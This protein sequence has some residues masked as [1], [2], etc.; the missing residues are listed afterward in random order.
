MTWNGIFGPKRKFESIKLSKTFLNCPKIWK[1]ILNFRTLKS[2]NTVFSYIC[3]LCRKIKPHYW[4]KYFN[5]EKFWVLQKTKTQNLKI[6]LHLE[7]RNFG[8]WV[9]DL[10]ILRAIKVSP[11]FRLLAYS[12]L[13]NCRDG[14]IRYRKRKFPKSIAVMLLSAQCSIFNKRYRVQVTFFNAQFSS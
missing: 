6:I 8:F 2:I 1:T 11:K 10:P 9:L 13:P 5:S 4:A 3:A 14:R 12:W 7:V